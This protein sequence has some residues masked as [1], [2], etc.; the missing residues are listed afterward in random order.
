MTRSAAVPTARQMIARRVNWNTRQINMLESTG[1]K[2][3]ESMRIRLDHPARRELNELVIKLCTLNA[4]YDLKLKQ[5]VE[6]TE[7]ETRG[8][9]SKF[10]AQ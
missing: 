5:E 3:F 8:I 9:Q 7:R 2:L 4:L 6:I 10:C 1:K